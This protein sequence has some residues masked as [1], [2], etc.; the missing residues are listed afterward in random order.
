MDVCVFCCSWVTNDQFLQPELSENAMLLQK[1]LVIMVI[2]LLC[3]MKPHW[4]TKIL[5]EFLQKLFL[6]KLFGWLNLRLTG[7]KRLWVNYIFFLWI[8]KVKSSANG[9][10]A[11]GIA[12]ENTTSSKS[13]SPKV[14]AKQSSA[15]NTSKS[16]T[17]EAKSP[18][19]DKNDKKVRRNNW[20]SANTDWDNT[21]EVVVNSACR[22]S[23]TY[24]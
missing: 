23:K 10:V 18:K 6:L 14:S 24:L 22:L 19:S 9:H 13:A 1:T 15:S 21:W 7:L 2:R 17:P 20:I 5:I 4:L 8:S 11:I 3:G 12:D 16:K